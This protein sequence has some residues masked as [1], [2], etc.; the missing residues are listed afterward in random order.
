MLTVFEFRTTRYKESS[1]RASASNLGTPL[2]TR[3]ALLSTNLARERLQIDTDWLRIT[4]PG[5]AGRN[6]LKI[7]SW[8]VE[9]EA[10]PDQERFTNVGLLNAYRITVWQSI[11]QSTFYHATVTCR[12]PQTTVRHISFARGNR[13]G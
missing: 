7:T 1:V 6:F 11:W 5:R 10:C 13:S 12:G 3:I 9:L 4:V 8:Y 2:K